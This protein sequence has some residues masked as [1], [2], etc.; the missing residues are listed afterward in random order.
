MKTVVAARTRVRAKAGE[1]T[2]AEEERVE[3]GAE[4]ENLEN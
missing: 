3:E 2:G 1:P 4:R